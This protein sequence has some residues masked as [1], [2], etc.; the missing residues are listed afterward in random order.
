MNFIEGLLTR[1]GWA[2][3]GLTLTHVLRYNTCL[4]AQ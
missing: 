3:P 2:S 4:W 1:K